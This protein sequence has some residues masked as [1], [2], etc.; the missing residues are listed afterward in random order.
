[1]KNYM[2]P[3]IPNGFIHVSGT[4]NKAFIIEDVKSK[5]RFTWIPLGFCHEC[6]EKI[7]KLSRKMSPNYDLAKSMIDKYQGIYVSTYPISKKDEPITNVRFRLAKNKATKILSESV[8]PSF[9]TRLFYGQEYDIVVECIA[10][11]DNTVGTIGSEKF[12]EYGLYGMDDLWIWT[13]TKHDGFSMVLK[14]GD[15]REEQEE[16]YAN[17]EWLESPE[18]GFRV[19]LIV[20]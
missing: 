9:H 4:W 19:V 15:S 16:V 6:E 8:I 14:K 11:L 12:E 13:L 2:N 10:R 7:A 17:D 5:K 3:P 20:L 1:M 18:I